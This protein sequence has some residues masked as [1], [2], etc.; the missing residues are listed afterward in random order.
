[1]TTT[2][3]AQWQSRPEV[4]PWPGYS[5]GM[6]EAQWG[7]EQRRYGA[8]HDRV[9]KIKLKEAKA[10]LKAAMMFE[11]KGEMGKQIAL[12]KALNQ[13]L[14]PKRTKGKAPIYPPGDGGTKEPGTTRFWAN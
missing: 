9:V 6:S 12:I 2:T 8:M 13:G 7:A 14:L 11:D 5:S 4:P 10:D 3:M 1:M